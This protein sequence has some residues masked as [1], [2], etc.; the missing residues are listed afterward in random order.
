[1]GGVVTWHDDPTVAE[2]KYGR[3]G[4]VVLFAVGHGHAEGYMLASGS[5]PGPPGLGDGYGLAPSTPGH[6]RRRAAKVVRGLRS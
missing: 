6:M 2:Q 4:R 1:V 3:A 5:L